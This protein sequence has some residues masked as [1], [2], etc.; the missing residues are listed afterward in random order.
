MGL[1]RSE[2]LAARDLGTVAVDVPE[3]GGTVHLRPLTGSERGR[4]ETE[5]LAMG[6]R[7]ATTADVPPRSS[8]RCTMTACDEGKDVVVQPRR[9]RRGVEQI[10]QGGGSGVPDRRGPGGYVEA[11]R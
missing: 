4:F 1:T 8:S 7:V 3:W 9:R 5:T 11:R 6:G 10:G 2:I